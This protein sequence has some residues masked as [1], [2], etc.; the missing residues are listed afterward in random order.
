MTWDEPITASDELIVVDSF[1]SSNDADMWRSTF[2]ANRKITNQ[3]W[4][5][6]VF[7]Y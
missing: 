6:P 1:N 4:S 5:S 7:N 2:W 3:Q